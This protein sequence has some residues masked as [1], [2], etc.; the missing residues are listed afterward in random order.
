M[1]ESASAIALGHIDG[2]TDLMLERLMALHPKV[3]DLSLGRIE[4]LLAALG[5]PERQLPPVI[6]IAGTNGKGSVQ[7]Y[8]VAMLEA[9]GTRVHAYTSPHLVRFAER[10]RLGDGTATVPI[11]ESYL[12][13]LLEECEAANG[14]DPITFF[15][16]TTAAA[17]LAFSRV[18]ADY[19]VLEVG[20][21]GRLDATN[22]V[23]SPA[24]S[25]ITP[26]SID[27][28]SFLGHDLAEI[29]GEK[30]GILKAGV[31]A[32]IG[33]QD[34]PA[35]GVIE[36]A[37]DAIGAPLIVC[38][39]DFEA[40]EQHGRL[41]YQ[42]GAGL[43]DLPRPHLFGHHQFANA[44]IA[45]ATL[46]CLTP[47]GLTE[48]HMAR[49]LEM[50]E[51]PARLERLG[52]G[53]LTE[54]LDPG[55]ELWLDG[56]HNE[57]A[58]KAIASAMVELEERAP[59]PLKIVVGM[60]KGKDVRAFLSPFAGLAA[61]VV[62]VDIPDQINGLAASDVAGSA[63]EAGFAGATAASVAAAIDQLVENEPEAQ[64]ILITGSLY[65][66]GDVLKQHRGYAI[67]HFS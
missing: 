2:R 42:D 25:V 63:A 34:D 18:A 41:V 38:G 21:G 44:A 5:H 64:R 55:V 62:A 15:E 43:L 8:L 30:A 24:V 59:K 58:G 16:I 47:H 49:G 1:S 14:G 20:L 61:T 66:A 57:A 28:Q 39:Q 29:A 32:I 36:R 45:I 23:A 6:H 7:A 22:V 31:P 50:A 52:R 12:V 17:M 27:H 53:T 46:R 67:G 40:F 60:M 65:L 54:G 56:G 3:I 26:V 35:L 48:A 37:A 33:P 13:E 10:I 11:N 51:W 19:L 4:R 9:A